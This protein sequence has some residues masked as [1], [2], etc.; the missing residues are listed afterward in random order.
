MQK[1]R[2]KL[3]CRKNLRTP[4]PSKH[5]RLLLF[6]PE[7]RRFQH[8]HQ[9]FAVTFLPGLTLF[10]WGK[11]NLSFPGVH[12]TP[13]WVFFPPSPPVPAAPRA[14]A[15]PGAGAGGAARSRS[16]APGRAGDG[17]RGSGWSEGSAAA[18]SALPA[19][20][21]AAFCSSKAGRRGSGEETLSAV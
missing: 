20:L 4:S 5:P 12:F 8:F 19:L 15:E 18:A 6:L 14:G 9:S 13:A 17:C 21:L 3:V 16:R 7:S 1:T 11:Q 10:T 2:Q